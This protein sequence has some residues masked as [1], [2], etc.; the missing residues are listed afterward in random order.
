[1]KLSIEGRNGKIEVNNKYVFLT[2]GTEEANTNVEH[3]ILFEEIEDII[4][5]KPT[6]DTY[7]FLSLYLFTKSFILN[8]KIKYTLIL[9]KTNEKDLDNNKK[10]YNFI[11][12]IVSNNNDIKVKEEKIIEE[13]REANSVD[14]IEPIIEDVTEEIKEQI[15]NIISIDDEEEK[16]ETEEEIVKPII[17]IVKENFVPK[18][19]NIIKVDNEENEQYVETIIENKTENNQS[20]NN[21]IIEET[22]VDKTNN[23]E[24]TIPKIEQEKE[25]NKEEI[26]EEKINLEKIEQL[27]NK[28]EELEKELKIITYKE[29]ILNKYI[30]ETQDRKKIDKLIIELKKLIEK[31]EKIKKEINKNEDI[32]NNYNF[33]RLKN[34]NIVIKNINK[35]LDYN[36]KDKIEDYIRTYEKTVLKY[37]EIKKETDTISKETDYKRK[38]IMISDEEYEKDINMFKGVKSNKDFITKYRKEAQ[39]NVSKIKKEIEKTIDPQ[40][41][42]KFVKKGIAEQTKT[43]AAITALNSLRPGHSRFSTMALSVLTGTFALHDLLGYDLKKVEYNEVTIK[44]SIVGIESVD[45]EKAKNM[46]ASSKN[47]IDKILYDCQ[48][49]YGDY[50]KFKEL[51]KNLLNLRNDIEKEELELQKVEDKLL[52]YKMQPRVKILKYKEQ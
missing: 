5:K 51:K 37:D 30:D 8:K 20:I 14:E 17:K 15:I 4:Y 1:M 6:K 10:I 3:I 29:L 28:L 39:E 45:T 22:P 31:L 42:Y 9:D 26:N 32:L 46:I 13:T 47:E 49:K 12:G 35:Y 19:T 50:P 41:K 2:I 38:E 34:G 27:E 16:E 33:L 21:K 24:V 11:K 48:K 40:V 18:E 7:G 23:I 36:D 52:D 43:L 44:E 25:E